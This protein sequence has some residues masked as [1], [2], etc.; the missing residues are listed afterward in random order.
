MPFHVMIV[1][2]TQN[3]PFVFW[4]CESGFQIILKY[5][6][7]LMIDLLLTTRYCAKDVLCVR[8]LDLTDFRLAVV[9]AA[10]AVYPGFCFQIK[11]GQNLPK[12][13]CNQAGFSNR[14]KPGT[15]RSKW[16]FSKL[17]YA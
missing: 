3:V 2:C 15:S 14:L 1:F 16:A 10:T 4:W 12:D 11:Y 8:A 9:A 17:L 5:F 13:E 6:L 7:S